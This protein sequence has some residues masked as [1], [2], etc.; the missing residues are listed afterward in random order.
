MGELG[1]R[2]FRWAFLLLFVLPSL[3][4]VGQLIWAALDG[5][6]AAVLDLPD[7]QVWWAVAAVGFSIMAL[8][9]RN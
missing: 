4:F 3:F 8:L 7:W 6:F 1:R 2:I 9:N 5:G